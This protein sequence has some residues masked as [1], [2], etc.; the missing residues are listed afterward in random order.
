VS[1][2][3]EQPGAE[4]HHAPDHEG[5]SVPATDFDGAWKEAIEFY[6]EA[7]VMFFFPWI[8]GEIDWAKGHSFLDKEFQQIV[9]DAATGRRYVDKL[10]KVS[11]PDGHE[12]WILIH[13]E[14]QGAADRQFPKRMD[15]YNHRIEM[16]MEWKWLAWRS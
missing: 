2:T 3:C 4:K 13:I 1:E 15:T 5:D 12:A 7:F 9:R 6:F 16:F 14:V 11:L 10:V 8:H